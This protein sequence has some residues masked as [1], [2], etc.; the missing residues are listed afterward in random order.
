METVKKS[1]KGAMQPSKESSTEMDVGGETGKMVKE[2]GGGMLHAIGE[3]IIE[4]AQ[5]TTELV[6]GPPPQVEVREREEHHENQ[7]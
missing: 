4:I 6:A 1:A 7:Q 3:T 5:H 2:K